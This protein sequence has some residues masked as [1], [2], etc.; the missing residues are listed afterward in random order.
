[1]KLTNEQRE[2]INKGYA[3]VYTTP[4]GAEYYIEHVLNAI[5]L[6]SASN[7]GKVYAFDNNGDMVDPSGDLSPFDSL[8]AAKTYLDGI[9]V[10]A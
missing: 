10:R 1:M 6:P 9:G 2:T 7:L 4:S 8:D 3:M 5:G